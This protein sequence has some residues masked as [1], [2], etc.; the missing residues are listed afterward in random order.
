MDI[1]ENSDVHTILTVALYETGLNT[2]LAGEGPF[3]VFAPT[4]NAILNLPEEALQFLLNDEG[5]LTQLLLYHVTGGTA[6]STD[7]Q[8]GQV[9]TTLL[10]QDVTVT[11]NNDGVFINDAQVIIADLIADN[12]VVHV[13][14]AVLLP[15]FELTTIYDII[16]GSPDHTI[17]TQA[18]QLT[19]LDA[20]VANPSEGPFTVFA[21]TDAA[22]QAL[23]EELLNAL[24][25][26]PFGELY[27]ALRHHVVLGE[28]LSSD[29]SDGQVITSAYGQDLTI[30]INSE[31]VF[32]NNAKVT[33]ADLQ[34]INGVVHVIDAVLIP[35]FGPCDVIVGGIYTDFIGIFG[36]APTPN[37]NGEC[38]TFTLPFEAWASEGYA[39][40]GFAPGAEYTFS[41]CE[42]ENAGSWSADLTVYDADFNVVATAQNSCDI[43]WLAENTTYIIV[44]N[45]NGACGP[46][47]Q[48]TETD[49]GNP[50]I[51]CRGF[52]PVTVMDLIE[53]SDVHSILAFAL[54]ATGL[55]LALRGENQLTVFAPTDAAFEALPEGTLDAL[56]ANPELLTSILLYHVVEGA[57][58]SGDLSNGQS[59]RT[60]N[61][62]DVAVTINSEGIF[63]NNAQVIVADLLADNGVLHVIDGVLLP[64]SNTTDLPVMPVNLYP[65]PASDFI[66]FTNKSTDNNN[67]Y[68]I[69][70]M[71]G[72]LMLNGNTAENRLN[73]S[74]LGQGMYFI[75]IFNESTVLTGR[76][77]KM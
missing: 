28:T 18:L 47:S 52:V 16:S 30:T 64:P 5:L 10:G 13:I 3:T 21:P 27:Q 76:F 24:I 35:E 29:L 53:R 33:I 25:A 60:L 7:L 19:S 46:A 20:I 34:A 17:L 32:I 54:N 41:I 4:D 77:V 42:G 23:G 1:I 45:E 26:N 51:T 38:E 44:I 73:I 63:I 49:N 22:F 55:D 67:R 62:E 12:G 31:G 15:N 8:D 68:E 50:S 36:G 48:N 61:G 14:D 6:L 74:A 11:I 37:Q 66:W 9:I 2:A 43:T 71:N 70:D 75:N 65:N 57:A 69:R 40:T 72:K 56:V 58:F 39:I 59:I